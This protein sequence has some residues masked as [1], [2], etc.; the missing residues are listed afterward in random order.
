MHKLG[1]LRSVVCTVVAQA[2]MYACTCTC[3][4]ISLDRA[5]VQSQP[6][7]Q[8]H[9]ALRRLHLTVKVAA[10]HQHMWTLSLILLPCSLCRAHHP[11]QP[12]PCEPGKVRC[13]AEEAA[14]TGQ[15]QQGRDR[16][17]KECGYAC[18][19]RPAQGKVRAIGFCRRLKNL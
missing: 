17:G 14:H 1:D 3:T 8:H 6:H 5:L 15:V 7:E 4:Y 13:A 16:Q 10:Q 11:V 18:G 2:C 12:L 9:H 19:L